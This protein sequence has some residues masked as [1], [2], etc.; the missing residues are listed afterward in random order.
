M[1]LSTALL[2]LATLAAPASA[3]DPE[4]VSKMIKWS[5]DLIE[6]A[7]DEGQNIIGGRYIE[8]GSRPW[9]V[10]VIGFTLCAGSLISP[11]VVMTGKVFN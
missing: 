4:R 9:L 7:K 8:P 2:G 1:K 3:D 6:D 10:P 5:D 11:S